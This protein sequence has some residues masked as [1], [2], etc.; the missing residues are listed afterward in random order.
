[1]E[2]NYCDGGVGEISLLA[3]CHSFFPSTY[4]MHYSHKVY[5]ERGWHKYYGWLPLHQDISH[6][7][8]YS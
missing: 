3:F 4:Y 1:M 7:S 2:S 8:Y 5:V 6:Q